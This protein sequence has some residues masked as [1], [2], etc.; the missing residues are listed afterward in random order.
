VSEVVSVP[1][2]ASVPASVPMRRRTLLAGAACLPLLAC[3][4]AAPA[5]YSG[6]WV[7]ADAER[8]HRLRDRKSGGLP[9]PEWERRAGAIVIGAG[10]SGLA[11]A[12]ALMRAGVD[13]VQV[14]DLEDSAG[15][16]SRGHTMAGMACPLGA[17]YLPVPGERAVEVIE[18]LEALGL[19]RSERGAP[20]YDERHLCH[21]PQERLNIAGH[22]FDG[23]LPPID[24]LPGADRATTLAQYRQFGAAVDAASVGGAFSMPTARSTWSAALDGLDATAF[25]PWLDAQG[26]NAPALRWYLDYC[27][28]D[29]YGAGASQVSAWAGLHYFASRHG[30]HAPGDGGEERDGVLTWPEGNAWL[31]RRLAAPLQGRLHTG[32]V[33]LRVNEERHA[34]SIDLWNAAEQRAERWTAP[35][36]VLAVPLFIAAR[37][38]AAPPAA[39][40]QA[41]A[42]MRHAPWLV[43]NLFL[44]QPLVDRGGAAP[45][46]DNVLYSP[47]REPQHGAPPARFALGYVDAMHQST[48]P[49]PGPTVLTAYWALGGDSPEQL[50]AQRARLLNEPWAAWARAVLQ[51]LAPAHP[52]LVDKVK[53]VDLMRYGHAMSVPLPGVRS[54]AALAEL[55]RSAG[56]VHF[57]HSD[58]A[59]YSVFEE[60]FFHGHAA[61]QRLLR[62]DS[63][64]PA[65]AA[66]SRLRPSAP[67]G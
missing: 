44:E 29:D 23:L 65:S 38:L 39:L 54:S 61:A 67:R 13:E 15:G 64:T 42:A 22:W 1:V 37:L 59:G 47:D 52:D 57:A 11:A 6:G 4:P 8:G 18:L 66:R 40:S 58:L 63:L 9:T 2:E 56:R 32:S 33:V 46:W 53:Q 25:A 12:R 55:A 30:F 26:L 3:T 24:A 43:A 60:A 16:N 41:V 34:V 17:H 36:L 19:R 5:A 21:S 45:A 14:F 10:I 51:D 7:G 50:Q 49:H 62:A 28:R 27:C 20:V 48:R 31:T 35:Q